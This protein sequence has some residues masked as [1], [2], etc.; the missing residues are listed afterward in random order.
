[1]K[2]AR[3]A[4]ID[5][6]KI[7]IIQHVKDPKLMLKRLKTPK[8]SFK[9]LIA[10]FIDKKLVSITMREENK[11][12]AN[13][14][15][16][17][18]NIQTSNFEVLTIEEYELQNRQEE[19]VAKSNTPNL[20]NLFDFYG[21]DKR[22]NQYDQF[23]AIIINSL[24]NKFPKEVNVFEIGLGTNNIDVP[25]NMGL[26]GSPGA[27]L[28][29]FRDYSHQINVFGADIDR[30]ILFNEERIQTFYINQL[31][32]DS[33]TKLHTIVSQSHLI[34]DDGLHTPEA[35]LNVLST[36]KDFMQSGSWIVIEDIAKSQM[37]LKIWN[38]VAVILKEFKV[39]LLDLPNAYIFIA[40]K[41]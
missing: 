33:V 10:P 24:L 19:S 22:R 34:I 2:N 31:D 41:K 26:H 25:S 39:T 6:W 37:N 40:K 35:N 5:A 14:L 4:F 32:I 11:I 1:M 15:K 20:G 28:R 38:L 17:L 8:N 7:R 9:L 18:V 30:R 3:R 29:A 27:S 23:Y 21:S 12:L 13:T 16:S 36:Y